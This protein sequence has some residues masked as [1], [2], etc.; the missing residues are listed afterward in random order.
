LNTVTADPC[1]IQAHYVLYEEERQR[2]ERTLK[3]LS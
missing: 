3:E 2:A 1:L